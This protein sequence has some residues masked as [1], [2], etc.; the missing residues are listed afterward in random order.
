MDS[1]PH[2]IR[3]A[4]A[5]S[6]TLAVTLVW[7]DGSTST[8]AMGPLIASR[9]VFKPLA[10]AALFA[11]VKVINGGRGI[12]WE[13]DADICADALWYEAHPQDNPHMS[14]PSAAE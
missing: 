14:H 3:S 12:G 11:R 13:G 9:K 6:A 2:H 5:D 1:I 10:D 7:D 8:K 4:S